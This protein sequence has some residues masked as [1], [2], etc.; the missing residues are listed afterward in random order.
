MRYKVI[1]TRV[2]NFDNYTILGVVG[3]SGSIGYISLRRCDTLKNTVIEF[4]WVMN[5]LPIS[6]GK[7][8]RAMQRKGLATDVRDTG[9]VIKRYRNRVSI[10][11]EGNELLVQ[12]TKADFE[13]GRVWDLSNWLDRWFNQK[14]EVNHLGNWKRKDMPDT[15]EIYRKGKAD[16]NG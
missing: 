6:F 12:F 9:I 7:T 10:V 8:L 15:I 16:E 1:E 14:W 13:R 3:A 2:F 5:D 4:R 11:S